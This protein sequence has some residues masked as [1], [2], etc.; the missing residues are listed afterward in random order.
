VFGDGV[1]NR[2]AWWQTLWP[3]R[4]IPRFSIVALGALLASLLSAVPSRAAE[5]MQLVY[6]VSHP[7][8]GDL[9]SYSC[10]VEHLGDGGSEILAREHIDARMLGIPVYRMDASDTERWQQN[11]LVSFSAVTTNANGRVEVT[12]EARGGRFV[13]TSPHGTLTTVASVHPAEPCTADF[14]DSTILM[15]PDTGTL[16]AVRVSGGEP[17]SLSINGAIIPVRKYE[18]GGTT[19]Y[20]VWLASNNLPVKFVID[21]NSGKATFTLAK[22]VSCDPPMPLPGTR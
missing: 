9:G 18:I 14:L 10:T 11:R 20:T 5:P 1:P 21:D 12:G 8:V 22:C 16:E 15:R 13:I 6:R 3:L 19:R 7:M 2:T 4:P 17:T